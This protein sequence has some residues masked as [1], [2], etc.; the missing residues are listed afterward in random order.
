MPSPF[1]PLLMRSHWQ[2]YRD[3]LED[4][5]DFYDKTLDRF[6]IYVYIYI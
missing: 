5:L 4:S 3:N 2:T 1:S 6:Y